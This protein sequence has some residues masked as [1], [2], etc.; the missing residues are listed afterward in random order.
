MIPGELMAEPGEIVLNAGRPVQTVTV[1]NMG[2]RPVQV[3]SHFH[4]YEVN[5][6]LQ[7]DRAATRGWRLDIAAGTAVR[8]E[9]GQE[10]TVELVPVAGDRIIYGFQARVMGK[11]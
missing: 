7:F 5:D 6:A 2:D 9:P 3:G 8:F 11:L 10:R 4:F 1:V